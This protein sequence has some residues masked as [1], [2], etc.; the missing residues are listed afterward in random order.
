MVIACRLLAKQV[1]FH[2]EDS[3]HAG[4]GHVVFNPVSVDEIVQVIGEMLDLFGFRHGYGKW[5]WTR[6]RGVTY[7]TLPSYGPS[8]SGWC[9]DGHLAKEIPLTLC[10]SFLG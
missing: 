5:G 2:L 3:N 7:P 1:D 6:M 9:G 4:I 10:F 8:P